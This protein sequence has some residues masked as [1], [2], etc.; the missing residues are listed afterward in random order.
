[1]NIHINKAVKIIHEGG[2]IAYPTE[3]TFC[4]GCDPF[5]NTAVLRL[6]KI[7]QRNIEKGLILIASD[8]SQVASLVNINLNTCNNIRENINPVT[9]NPITW[10]FPATKKVPPCI[11]SKSNSIIIH[12]TSHPVVKLLCQKYGAP[13]VG[14]SANIAKQLPAKTFKQTYSNFSNLIDFIIPGNAGNSKKTIEF[15]DIQTS[16]LIHTKNP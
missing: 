15:R 11:A 2:I 6:I 16:E 5:N 10:I 13:I 12:V 7:K 8:W 4:F 14:T 1:M 9:K 3:G